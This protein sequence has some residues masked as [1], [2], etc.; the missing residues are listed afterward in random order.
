MKEKIKN[1]GMM[2]NAFR[3]MAGLDT[4]YGYDVAVDD[5]FRAL[6]AHSSL[7]EVTCFYEPN[8]FQESAI[9]RK[10]RSLSRANKASA[11]LNLF[12]E[13]D[14]LQDQKK[15][16]IDILH[17]VSM[18]FMPLVYLREFFAKSAFPITYTIHGASYPNYI[19]SFYLMK[20]LMPFRPYDS[21][22]CTSRAVK[23]AVKAMLENI[24]GALNERYNT[25]IKYEGRLD[26]VP[27][28]VDTD[29]FIPMDKREVRNKLDLPV[30]PFIILWLGRFSAYDKADLLPIILMY[31]RLLEKNLDK[32][33]LLILAGH[34]RK[35]IPFI[36]AIKSYF[37]EHGI[38][39]KVKIIPNNDVANRNLLFAAAD[40]FVSPIDN[41]QET[42]GI[43][44]I[45]AMACGTPQVV[46]DWDGYKDTVIDG[47]TGFLIPTYWMKCDEDIK[48]A[49]MFPSEP[50]HRTVL[51]HLLMGQSVA[52][53]LQEYE[54]AIQRLIDHPEL[55]E[56]MS[57]NSVK[58]AREKFGWANVIRLYEDLWSELRE[59]QK[60][61]PVE[62][63]REDLTFM[64]PIYCDAFK[65]YP[66]RF[67]SD[68]ETFVITPEGENVLDGKEPIPKHYQ[69]ED[70]L[71]EYQLGP[72]ILQQLREVGSKG[73]TVAQILTQYKGLYHE[74]VVRR[75]TMWLFKHGLSYLRK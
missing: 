51:H 12:S 72:I 6:I 35:T 14:I 66:T 55:R 45:E 38:E 28:G 23:Y 70:I 21:L 74:S 48:T 13:L 68:Q 24:S 26:I 42:F 41:V 17:N 65:Q 54:Q 22:I 27:L 10:Y 37:T 69:I 56:M 8:H 16:D 9:L 62:D 33:L 50:T 1:L 15:V 40:V 63:R 64:Q 36:P 29:K 43:T 5:M 7:E 39:N 59:Q 57:E 67:L 52:L 44:P 4:V 3:V 30:D 58:I 11:K 19:E 31:K 71:Q 61:T 73:L 49:A 18:E 47:E 46:S 2:G 25:N 34:D 60:A 32:D 75:S 53:D 20:L